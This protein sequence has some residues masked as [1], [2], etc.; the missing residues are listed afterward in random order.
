MR[1][2]ARRRRPTNPPTPRPTEAPYSGPPTGHAFATTPS[3]NTVPN[4]EPAASAARSVH[5]PPLMP[6][7]RISLE[8]H[9]RPR[10]GR[11]ATRPTESEPTKHHRPAPGRPLCTSPQAAPPD[12]LPARRPPLPRPITP[13]FAA[14]SPPP[15][16]LPTL[17][18]QAS[19]LSLRLLP[20]VRRDDSSPLGICWWHPPLFG[21]MLHPSA[22]VCPNIYWHTLRQSN[23]THASA[24]RVNQPPERH[25]AARA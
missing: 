16:T 21:A 22:A 1:D 4:K 10:A 13:I 24:R 6:C 23:R 3:A 14:R 5:S 2:K 20:A 11:P 8:R 25:L 15:H 12:A 19:G 7:P 17:T 9:N 18:C